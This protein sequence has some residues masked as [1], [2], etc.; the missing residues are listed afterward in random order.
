MIAEVSGNNNDQLE[1]ALEIMQAAK[2][3]GSNSVK[4]QT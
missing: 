4:L 2:N 1:R 3:V